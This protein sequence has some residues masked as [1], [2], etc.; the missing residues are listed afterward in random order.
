MQLISGL[1][2]QFIVT[3]KPPSVLFVPRSLASPS[4]P[5]CTGPSNK[6]PTLAGCAGAAPAYSFVRAMPSDLYPVHE[7]GHPE[8]DEVMYVGFSTR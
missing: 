4:T 1:L 7:Q 2:W 8:Q 5:C 6:E 3:A